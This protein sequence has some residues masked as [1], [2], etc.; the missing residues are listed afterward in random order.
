MT[1]ED[2]RWGVTALA[3]LA[4]VMFVPVWARHKGLRGYLILPGLWLVCLVSFLA[5]VW[6]NIPLSPEQIVIVNNWSNILRAWVILMLLVG[7]AVLLL[8]NQR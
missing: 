8:W 1:P 3:V 7:E 2:L 4:C 6:I 5:Y